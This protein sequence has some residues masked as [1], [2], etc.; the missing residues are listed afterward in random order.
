[1]CT[2]RCTPAPRCGDKA[3]DPQFGENCDDGVNSG[4]PG[5]CTADCKSF[6]PLVSCGN[7]KIDA[8]EECDDGKANNGTANSTCDIH[9]RK[10]C[11]NGVKDTGETCD[12]GVNDGSYGGCTT[13]C[14][15]A[16][17]CGDS[18]KNGP[19]QC[20]NGTS[21]NV[22]PATAYGP[23][24]CTTACTFAPYCGDGR[25]QTQF[26]EECDGDSSCTAACKTLGPK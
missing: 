1:M 23:G 9:C 15:I 18:I 3:V 6:V 21:N 17:Y 22:S 7:G 2:N 8:P 16:G 24:I 12:N 20:D 19:E 25:V 5:S 10:K 4:Q 14:Q 11:G 13:N 26:G